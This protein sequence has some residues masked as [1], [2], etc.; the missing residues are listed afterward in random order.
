M[1]PA[2]W[3][4]LA[5]ELME[6]SQASLVEK[7]QRHEIRLLTGGFD[8]ACVDR[9][10]LFLAES[11]NGSG[12]IEG[13]LLCNPCLDG[14]RWAFE[15]YRRRPDAIRGTMPYLMHQTMRQLQ[16]EGVDSVSLC[17]VPGLHCQTPL[18]GDSP[19]ARWSMVIATRYFSFIHDTRGMYHYKTRFRPQFVNRYMA[20]RPRLSLR[21]AWS[22]VRVL[23]VLDLRLGNVVRQS[24][25]RL[26]S[27]SSRRMLSTPEPAAHL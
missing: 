3:N 17:L 15:T 2:R 11:E 4:R 25:G 24:I 1:S 13:F 10:R 7:P 23:G 14:T 27:A 20:V 16:V 6:I 9:R 26:K 8:A 21:A 12:R 22:F 5:A 18:P 19:L